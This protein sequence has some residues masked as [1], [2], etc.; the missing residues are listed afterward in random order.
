MRLAVI[1]GGKMG[2]AIIAGV[3]DAGLVRGDAIY[4]VE[5]DAARRTDLVGRH[6][7][8]AC[9][10][11]QDAVTEADA[12]IIAVKPDNVLEA[13][14]AM[15]DAIDPRATVI[16]IAAGVTTESIE[17]QLEPDHPVVRVMP[18]LGATI[19]AGAAGVAG[20][21]ST[22]EEDMSLALQIFRAVGS[23]RRV[24]EDHLDAVTALSGSGPA[25]VFRLAEAMTD[26]GVAAG[27][28]RD[29]AEEL[30]VQT[31]LGAARLLAERGPLVEGG[32]SAQEW[33]EAVTSKGGTTAAAL[34]LLGNEGFD[35][36]ICDAVIAAR[37]RS[38][39]LNETGR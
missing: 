38:I 23:A 21:R 2:E 31:V 29:V 19:G 34:E 4:L 8:I 10:T 22:T 37:D 28:D 13:L 17:G 25:Y 6:G 14:A 3:I 36:I 39:E 16:S 15:R 33:R 20:G 5:V 30:V 9:A 24:P 27:L 32:L 11:A 1:G 7:V 35:Q 12:V 26:A 18:N